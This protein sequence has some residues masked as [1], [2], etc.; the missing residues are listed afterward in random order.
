MS[1]T[2]GNLDSRLLETYLAVCDSGSMTA[3]A[4]RLGLSQGAISQQIARL[5]N[6][7]SLALLER[8]GRHLQ[9]TPAGRSLRFHARRVV[10]ELRECE[11]AMHT[12]AN[13]SYPVISVGILDTLGKNLMSTLVQTLEPLVE[14]IQ[15]RASVNYNHIGDLQNGTVD[16]LITAYKF[17][18]DEYDVYPLVDEPLVLLAPKGAVRNRDNVDLED[19]ASRFAMIRFANA[20]RP[21]RKLADDYLL[22]RGITASR[23]IETDQSASVLVSLKERQG[24][25]IVSPFMLLDSLFEAEAIDVIALPPPG[26]VRRINLVTRPGKFGDIPTNL[27]A[28]CR[29]HLTR[30]IETQ[31]VPH[32]GQAPRPQI[33][34][35]N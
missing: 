4:R 27:A 1:E 8:H 17:D 15:I 18:P 32:L 19:L 7:L 13:V 20:R 14:Q 31:I 24:F 23:S 35:Q 5:E 21:M 11:R 6:T 12:F 10:D 16:V 30:A 9:L 3:A 2:T 34:K 22:N 29:R 26:P 25:A 33:L 28:N